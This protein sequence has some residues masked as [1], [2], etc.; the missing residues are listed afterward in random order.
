[1]LLPTCIGDGRGTGG[2]DAISSGHYTPLAGAFYKKPCK[3][4]EWGTL[5]GPEIYLWARW[6][7]QNTNLS[8]QPQ[9]QSHWATHF[10]PYH[11]IFSSPVST[12][13]NRLTVTLPGPQR[14]IWAL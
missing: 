7:P 1:M 6:L 3:R 13:C 14:G 4:E 11:A 5:P 8:F 12:L 2:T 10:L 9:S